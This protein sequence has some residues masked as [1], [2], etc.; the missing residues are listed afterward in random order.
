V[1]TVDYIAGVLSA[2]GNAL[3]TAAMF[4]SAVAS[5]YAAVKTRQHGAKLDRIMGDNIDSPDR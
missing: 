3:A 2:I 4:L 1:S 5:V